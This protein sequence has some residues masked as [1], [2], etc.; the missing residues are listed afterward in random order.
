MHGRAAD[1]FHFPEVILLPSA[2]GRTLLVR[3][4]RRAGRRRQWTCAEPIPRWAPAAGEAGCKGTGRFLGR[5]PCPACGW[6][7]GP[8]LPPGERR[9]QRGGP[10][11]WSTSEGD[12]LR[13]AKEGPP[14]RRALGPRRTRKSP[15]KWPCWCQE[16][17]LLCPIRGAVLA[18]TP[19]LSHGPCSSS[20]MSPCH[21]ASPGSDHWN[22]RLS[23]NG[24]DVFWSPS[25]GAGQ[26]PCAGGHSCSA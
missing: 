8:P 7:L 15:R 19:V 21:L 24:C 12:G 11:P 10:C 5:E 25:G 3:W 4:P 14:R 6:L 13:P 20:L 26:T 17:R 23:A 2:G 16:P 9:W 18:H 22:P 1:S